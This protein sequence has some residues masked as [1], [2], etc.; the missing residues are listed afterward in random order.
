MPELF[1]WTR[2]ELSARPDLLRTLVPP[3]A[4]EELSS[5]GID[6]DGFVPIPL[7]Q[8]RISLDVSCALR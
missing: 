5:R 4:E 3:F 2:E 8:L 7:E 6:I 1:N